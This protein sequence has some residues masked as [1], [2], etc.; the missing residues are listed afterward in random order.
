LDL[1]LGVLDAFGNLDFLLAG[2]QRHLAHLLEIHP[3]GVVEDVEFLVGLEVLRRRRSSSIALLVLV[4]VHLG[5]VDDVELHVAEPLHDGLDVIRIDEVVGQD[6]VDVVEGEVVLLL[7]ELDEFADLFLATVH[8]TATGRPRSRGAEYSRGSSSGQGFVAE[9]RV[10]RRWPARGFAAWLRVPAGDWPPVCAAK[11]SS[12][13][14]TRTDSWGSGSEQCRQPHLRFRG[15][16]G[17]KCRQRSGVAGGEF[18]REDAGQQFAVG[19][20]PQLLLPRAGSHPVARGGVLEREQAKLAHRQVAGRLRT[21]RGLFLR[22]GGPLGR[23]AFASGAI[24][25]TPPTAARFSPRLWRPPSRGARG[26]SP[27]RPR[28]RSPRQSARA[29]CCLRD[30]FRRRSGRSGNRKNRARRRSVPGTPRPRGC[31]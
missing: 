2:E 23:V 11:P 7:G 13:P 18:G 21:G 17:Q 9:S 30:R 31:G 25:G 1:D 4:A 27:G 19:D 16:R 15:E 3:D 8:S 10:L 29:R 20:V 6:L 5:G 22:S 14:H 24:P 28:T 12:E 26:C